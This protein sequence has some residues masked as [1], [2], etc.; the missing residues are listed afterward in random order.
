MIL[1]IKR[2]FVNHGYFSEEL[3]KSIFITLPKISGIAKCIKKTP[4]NETTDVPNEPHHKVNY[5]QY[6]A[7]RCKKEHQNNMTMCD[8]GFRNAIFGLRSKTRYMHVH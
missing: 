6:V 5:T 8:K 2:P 3:N 4:Q 1:G 7:E